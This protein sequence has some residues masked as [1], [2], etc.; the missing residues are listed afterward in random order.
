MN[1]K[2]F[3]L[4]LLLA[5][6]SGCAGTGSDEQKVSEYPEMPEAYRDGSY[7]YRE[8]GNNVAN[9][10]PL[11]MS[12]YDAAETIADEEYFGTVVVPLDESRKILEER[13]LKKQQSEKGKTNEQK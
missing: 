8:N 1:I 4:L 3:I 11:G 12:I 7:G 10:N 6:L 5:V 9:R 2:L 13:K